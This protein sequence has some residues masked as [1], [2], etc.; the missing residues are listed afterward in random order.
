MRIGTH[1][2]KSL[3]AA[4][5]YYTKQGISIIDV[6]RKLATDEIAIGPPLLAEGT[7][8]C[9]TDGRYWITDELKPQYSL[10]PE[11]ATK[12]QLVARSIKAAGGYPPAKGWRV[13]GYDY[14][15]PK[16]TASH[17]TLRTKWTVRA[18]VSR[19]GAHHMTGK[20]YTRILGRGATLEIAL[21]KAIEKCKAMRASAK[22][23]V[24]PASWL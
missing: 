20:V 4:A 10:P 2:F 7:L 16:Q 11:S 19:S 17:V 5:V 6:Q 23:T 3:H 8:G 15:A 13:I 18:Q 24:D 14:T 12:G 9:D 22:A 1:H 21:E